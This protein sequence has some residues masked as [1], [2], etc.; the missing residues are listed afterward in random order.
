MLIRTP[1]ASSSPTALANPATAAAA[2]WRALFVQ[3]LGQ[4]PMPLC[5][6]S[7]LHRTGDSGPVT[8]RVR[9]CVCRGLWASLPVNAKNPA[10]RNPA[11]YES[12]LPVFTTD[13]RMAKAGEI[14]LGGGPVEA[15]WWA[16]EANTQWRVRGTAWLL[17]PDVETP[18]GA[19][20]RAAI[21][22][23]MRRFRDGDAG[24]V[25]ASAAATSATAA[26]AA[27]A[28]AHWSW[29]RELTAHFGNMSPGMRGSFRNPPPG[30]PR[31]ARGETGN[32]Y[33]GEGLGDPVDNEHLDDAAARTNFRVCVIVPEEVDQVDLSQGDDPRRW[34]YT[35]VGEEDGERPDGAEVINGWAKQELWP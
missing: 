26:G 8:P 10:P 11:V 6:V 34:L 31:P 12:D 14:S 7:T 25:V 32:T 18:T 29:S 20:A 9:N 17:G 23:H 1:Q 16:S 35:Y 24:G 33:P 2:P 27:S 5:A 21:Q 19:V 30:Q 22:K 28:S 13:A 3:H 4:M 15:V